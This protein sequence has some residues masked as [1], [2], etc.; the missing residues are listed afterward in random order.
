M[1]KFMMTRRDI[2]KAS[3]GAAVVGPVG[4]HR[5]AMAQRSAGN[6]WLYSTAQGA[7]AFRSEDGGQWI[8]TTPTGLEWFFKETVRTAAYV[9]LS[10]P[11]RR[12][13]LRLHPSYLEW[14]K[15][16]NQAWTRW[17]QGRWV[18]PGEVPPLSDYLIRLAYLVPSDRK[19]VAHYEE[20]IGVIMHFVNELYAQS[21]QGSGAQMKSLPLKMKAD[22]PAVALIRTSKPAS[23]YNGAPRY[24]HN[25]HAHWQKLVPDIPPY[26]GVPQKHLILLFAETFGEEP[27]DVEWPG[28]IARG[29]RFSKAGGVGIFSAWILRDEFC[30]LSVPQQRQLFFDDTPIAGRTAMGWRKPDS[31][32]FQFIEDGVGAITHEVAHALGLAHDTRQ[33]GRDIMGQGFRQIRWNFSD[34]PQAAKGGSFSEDNKRMLLSSRYLASDLDV[35]DA[36]PPELKVRIVDVERADRSASVTIEVHASDDRSLRAILFY[37]VGQDSVVGGRWLVGKEQLFTQKLAIDLPRSSEIQIDVTVTDNGGNYTTQRVSPS[38][39]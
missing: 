28:T 11:T 17:L 30:A 33:N 24:E 36:T 29:A 2:L 39:R 22:R 19:P 14:R 8:E 38:I 37:S 27:S 31:P 4:W 3:A 18:S 25:S 34:P 26:V 6:A 21:L 20:K 13:W 5:T 1:A 32:R 23:Y 15:E 10:D 7:G 9:E 12:L 16:P 35:N